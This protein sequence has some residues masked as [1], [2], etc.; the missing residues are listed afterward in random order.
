MALDYCQQ[1][2]AI[3]REMERKEGEAIQL[4]NMGVVYRDKGEPRKA[5][6]HLEQALKIFEEIGARLEI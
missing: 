4:H 1:A 3:N 5:L 2:L 6:E